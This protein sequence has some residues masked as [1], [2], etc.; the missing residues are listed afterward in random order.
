MQPP[1]D[2]LR[3]DHAITSQGLAVLH[4]IATHVRA[5]GSF[6]GA[7]VA[8]LLRFLREFLLAV[9]MRKES[10]VV[11]PAAAMC[12]DERT[13]T[14]VGDMVRM[15]EEVQE[16]LHTLILFWEP[17]GELTPAE[18][19]AFAD[20]AAMFAARVQRM[21][22]IEERELFPACEATV[23]AD[24]LLGWRDQFAELERERG[25][26]SAWRARLGELA[27]RWLD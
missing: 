12:G 19:R 3:A 9:H 14:L 10:D 7:D 22:E 6:P 21:Q 18:Q 24:D 2:T 4:A 8:L 15:Q 16:L 11:C 17:I 13:A 25:A 27:Q 26:G 20:T 1:T 5:G 23:P